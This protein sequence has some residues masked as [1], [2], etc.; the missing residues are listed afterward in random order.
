MRFLLI[1]L[2]IRLR[3]PW[4]PRARHTPDEGDWWAF[5]TLMAA[6]IVAEI[7]IA[8]AIWSFRR[9]HGI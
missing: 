7:G 3:V 1:D 6:T 4:G 8:M 5:D 2:A 9:L